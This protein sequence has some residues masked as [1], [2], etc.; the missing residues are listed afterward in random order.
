M[1]EN[2]V[3]AA[4]MEAGMTEIDELGE[5]EKVYRFDLSNRFSSSGNTFYDP[6]NKEYVMEYSNFAQA[7]H[8]LKHAHDDYIGFL[9]LDLTKPK[10][11]TNYNL[12]HEVRG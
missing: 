1:N 3:M 12:Q 4:Q 9:G 10:G 8:E 5:S 2:S 6:K 11:I 7:A